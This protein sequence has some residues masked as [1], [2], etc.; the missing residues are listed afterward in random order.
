KLEEQGIFV[1]ASFISPYK[2][3]RDAVR[4]LCNNYHEIH[5]N[6]PIEICEQRDDTGVYEKARRGEIEHFPGINSP[7]QAPEM[8]ELTIDISN[9][10]PKTAAKQIFNTIA[11]TI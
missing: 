10:A 7:Y 3:S 1:I 2:V 4:R 9:T 11:N 8:P 6:T 5:V